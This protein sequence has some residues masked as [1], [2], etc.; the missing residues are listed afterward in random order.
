[1]ELTL[2]WSAEAGLA[3]WGRAYLVPDEIVL[4]NLFLMF[5]ATLFTS[6]PPRGFPSMN[7]TVISGADGFHDVEV[8]MPGDG[9][10]CEVEGLSN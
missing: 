9:V 3:E 10:A 8:D 6:N 7:L 4:D 1:M 2:D 5:R